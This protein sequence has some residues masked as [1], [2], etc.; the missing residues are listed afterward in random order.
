MYNEAPSARYGKVTAQHAPAQLELPKPPLKNPKFK[1]VLSGS[2]SASKMR[3]R[4]ASSKYGSGAAEVPLSPRQRRSQ[5]FAPDFFGSL[6]SPTSGMPTV[7][8]A[9]GRCSF[10]PP[11]SQQQHQQHHNLAHST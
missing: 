4:M 8:V 6:V 11:S 7:Q 9:R 10:I 5:E 3:K 1:P 2:K